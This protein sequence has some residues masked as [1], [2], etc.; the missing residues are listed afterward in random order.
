[1]PKTSDGEGKSNRYTYDR[2]SH[3]KLFLP[4]FWKEITKDSLLG[5]ADSK[6]GSDCVDLQADLYLRWMYKS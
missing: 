3:S 1:M 4:P 2:P 6:D 5:Q